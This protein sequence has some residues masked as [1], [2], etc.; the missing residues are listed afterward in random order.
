MTFGQRLK[1]YREKRGLSQEK[2]AEKIGATRELI[3]EWESD[4]V[5]ISS[6]S[7][8]KLCEIL[9]VD[10]DELLTGYKTPIVTA[11]IC[12]SEKEA[13]LALKFQNSILI[14]IFLAMG[15]GISLLMST[16]LV[17]CILDNEDLAEIIINCI[18]SSFNVLAYFGVFIGYNR[19]LN[20]QAK[21]YSNIVYSINGQISFFNKYLRIDIERS[22]SKEINYSDL[23]KVVETDK[24][25]IIS[26]LN[27]TQYYI[28]KA[29]EKSDIDTISHL[30][31]GARIYKNKRAI[32]VRD[33]NISSKKLNIMNM[34]SEML[35]VFCLYSL[36]LGAKLADFN[37]NLFVVSVIV[38]LS[39]LIYGIYLKSKKFKAHI[40]LIVSSVA[41]VLS[42]VGSVVY[43]T[44]W[45]TTDFDVVRD[46]VSGYMEQSEINW[47]YNIVLGENKKYIELTH[48]ELDYTIN[49]HGFDDAYSTKLFYKY[50]LPD[51][52]STGSFSTSRS[53]FLNTCKLTIKTDQEFLYSYVENSVCVYVKTNIENQY[54]VM[55]V[56]DDIGL[57]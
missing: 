52:S 41:L 31:K 28:N 32:T 43:M 1:H 7:L 57:S 30:L 36:V 14:S 42:L 47:E 18:F 27:G 13:K 50:D 53:Q 39:A 55:K 29:D 12:K 46:K 2:L 10:M 21:K 25:I 19:S 11:R 16:E 6:D 38:P 33:D 56:I 17:M 4:S 5:K 9:D 34:F 48:P 45:N 40:L 24:Y 8:D 23:K 44:V 15:I 37:R 22:K 35:L 49:I 54:N 51:V 20:K 26:L 3:K